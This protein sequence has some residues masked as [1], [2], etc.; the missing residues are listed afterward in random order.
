MAGMM[1]EPE[2]E[3]AAPVDPELNKLVDD[4]GEDPNVSEDEQKAYEDFVLAGFAL[5]YNK[6]GVRPEITSLL[7]SDLSDL[8]AIIDIPTEGAEGEAPAEGVEPPMAEAAPGTPPEAAPEQPAAE[9]ENDVLPIAAT[10]TIVVLQLMR[11]SDET[12]RPDDAIVMHG[13]REIV[14][15]LAQVWSSQHKVELQ[16]GELNHAFAM[17]TDLYREAATAAGYVDEEQLKA[18]W[19]DIVEAD[20]SGKLGEMLPEIDQINRLAAE[21]AD[22]APMG[23]ESGGMQP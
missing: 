11:I 9:S 2:E 21:D 7:D 5:I 23:G 12:D 4:E 3:K 18:V 1:P 17:A 19:S 6:S 16:Q 10:A 20:K 13:G 8:R 15:E 14:E 22:A